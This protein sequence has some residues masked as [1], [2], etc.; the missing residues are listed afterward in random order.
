MKIF[1]LNN[2]NELPTKLIWYIFFLSMIG[3]FILKSISN[4]HSSDLL[5]TPF[6]KQLIFFIPAIF[7]LLLMMLLPR[8]TIHKYSYL[9][10]LFGILIVIMPFF[11]SPHA[12][13]YRW[14]DIGLP[15]AIQQVNLQKFYYSCFSKISI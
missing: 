1:R 5:S 6:F 8:Y 2:F 13:T 14:L 12:R 11:G 9:F 15:F 7:T 4:H 10:F 3:L